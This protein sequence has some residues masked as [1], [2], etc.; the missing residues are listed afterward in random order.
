MKRWVLVWGLMPVFA[1]AQ[2]EVGWDLLQNVEVTYLQDSV[3][4]TWELIP[5]FSEDILALD[6]QEVRVSGFVIPVTLESNEFVLSAFPFASCFFC[7]GAGPESV[8]VI[9]PKKKMRIQTDELRS[10][11]GRFSILKRSDG[12]LY[13]LENARVHP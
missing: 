4:N 5:A 11:T 6:G 2:Q 1:L 3:H 7:G 9:Y 8:V 13:Q 12:L 10:F